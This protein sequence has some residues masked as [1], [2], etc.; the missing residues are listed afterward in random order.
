MNRNA[1]AISCT[2]DLYAGDTGRKEFFFDV[3]A[4]FDI[5][6]LELLIIFFG[7]PTGIPRL[8]DTD[9]KA[10]RINFLT[11]YRFPPSARSYLIFLLLLQ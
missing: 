7:T 10:M 2:F 4:D 1:R 5:L 11:H 3:L 6:K 9:A 8:N